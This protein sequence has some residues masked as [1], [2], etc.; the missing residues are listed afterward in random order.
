MLYIALRVCWCNTI[1]LNEP[2]PSK[3]KCDESKDRIY[4]ELEHIFDHYPKYRTKILL[5]DF[6]ATLGK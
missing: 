1:V 3:G 4:E 5:G 2:P 6:N